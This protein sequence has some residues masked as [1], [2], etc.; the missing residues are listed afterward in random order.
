MRVSAFKRQSTAAPGWRLARFDR[1][2][3]DGLT[4]AQAAAVVGV[5]RSSLYQWGRR[6]EPKSR[7]LRKPRRKT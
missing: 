4:A 3:R 7:R 1:G 5:G 2:R 6:V